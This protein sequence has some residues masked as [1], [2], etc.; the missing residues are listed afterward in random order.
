MKHEGSN[1]YTLKKLD[2]IE[3]I[4]RAEP[5]KIV[6]TKIVNKKQLLISSGQHVYKG[7][8]LDKNEKI[9]SISGIFYRTSEGFRIASDDTMVVS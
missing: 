5:A 6:N 9:A 4:G 8:K 2:D 1:S 3:I 7:Q